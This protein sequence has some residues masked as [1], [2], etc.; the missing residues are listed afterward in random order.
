[1]MTKTWST[2]AACCGFL[3]GIIRCRAAAREQIARGTSVI[4]RSTVGFRWPNPVGWVIRECGMEGRDCVKGT[5]S[6]RH[7]LVAVPAVISQACRPG[8]S[9]TGPSIAFT[10]IPQAD[11]AGSSRNDIIEGSV[12]GASP[13]Q[14]IVLYAKTGKWWVQ[15]LT[16]QPMTELRRNFKWTNA[17]HLGTHYAALLVKDGYR[18]Q[19]ALDSLPQTDDRIL[20]VAVVSGAARPPSPVKDFSG[21]PWRLRDAPSSRGG[22]NVYSP[23]N[24]SVDEQGAMRLRIAKTEKDWSCAEAS[25]T[26]S[27][28]YG[29]Y[30]FVVR[31]LDTLEPAAVF[32]MFTYDYASGALHNREMNIEISRWG[33]PM[34]K[35]AQYVLQ[36]YYVAANVHRFN[37]PAGTLT[38]SLRWERDR[39]TFRTLRGST[40]VSEHVFTEGVPSPGIESIRVVLYIYR[41]AVVKLQHPM[42]VVIERFTYFP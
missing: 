35:N 32:G 12:T 3:S 23:S 21:Y 17:T 4:L 28:G 15:P 29:T 5:I 11:P 39:T 41:E 1:M 38:F 30:E 8:R 14:K 10:R 2:T 42:E 37:V 9:S 25:M 33:D 40:N 7:A 31:G 20:A 24:I 22:Q 6:R 34:K 18:P 19:S 36:P 16:D 26:R 13:G 27:L